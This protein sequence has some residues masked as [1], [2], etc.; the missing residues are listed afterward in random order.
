[1]REQDVNDLND[2]HVVNGLGTIDDF[3][4]ENVNGVLMNNGNAD[5]DTRLPNENVYVSAASAPIMNFG[6]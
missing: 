1:M 6:Q 4:T 5:M 2:M 3:L